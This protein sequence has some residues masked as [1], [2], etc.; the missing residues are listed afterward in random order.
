VAN[1][2]ASIV[3]IGSTFCSGE[4]RLGFA[5]AM[6]SWRS[7]LSSA[8]LQLPAIIPFVC[9]SAWDPSAALRLLRATVACSSGCCLLACHR[10]L[11]PWT[12]RQQGAATQQSQLC[13]SQRAEPAADLATQWRMLPHI[14]VS[15]WTSRVAR[16]SAASVLHDSGLLQ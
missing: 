7:T 2:P 12:V 1:A 16:L 5:A 11:T 13:S 8:K 9:H 14:T 3:M 6:L 15:L 4:P 10:Q